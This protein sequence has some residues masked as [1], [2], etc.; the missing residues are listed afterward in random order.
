MITTFDFTHNTGP[1]KNSNGI[2]YRM[3]VTIPEDV[4]VSK[5]ISV[6]SAMNIKFYDKTDKELFSGVI[7]IISNRRISFNKVTDDFIKHYGTGKTMFG[8]VLNAE[9]EWVAKEL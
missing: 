5:S 2:G 3:F 8:Y 9:N 1:I 4:M 6:A 7:S